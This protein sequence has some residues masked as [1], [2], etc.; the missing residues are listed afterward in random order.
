MCQTDSQILK[1]PESNIFCEYHKKVVLSVFA[2]G[3]GTLCYEWKKDGDVINYSECTGTE[4]DALTI[5]NFSHKHQGAYICVV[6]DGQKF[7]KSEPV[8]LILGMN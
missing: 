6:N 3:Y 4:T 8:N 5:S 1:Q 2:V 7:T